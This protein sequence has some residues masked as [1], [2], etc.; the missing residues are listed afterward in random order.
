MDWRH[1]TDH[2]CM[3]AVLAK[4]RPTPANV[5]SHVHMPYITQEGAGNP[6]QPGFFGGFM[7]R[8]YDPLFV[9]GRP[10]LHPVSKC[11]S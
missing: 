1:Q 3:G 11:R 5:I 9:L 2:P 4:L 6:P 10:Q 8:S 7:G